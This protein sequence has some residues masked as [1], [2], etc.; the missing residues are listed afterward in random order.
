MLQH[1]HP[2]VRGRSAGRVPTLLRFLR[3]FG[4]ALA[5]DVLPMRLL[6]A[7]DVLD[8]PLRRPARHTASCRRS[9]GAWCAWWPSRSL[10]YFAMTHYPNAAC[11]EQ[12]P[13]SAQSSSSPPPR[14]RRARSIIRLTLL[15]CAA[16]FVC[17]AALVTWTWVRL[18]PLSLARADAVSVTV[19][20]RNDRLLRAYTAPDG[21]WRLPAELK[22]VDPRYIAMLIAFEDKRFRR[23][24]GVD[25][26]AVG[27]AGGSCCGIAAS[28]PAVR[29]SPCR[30]RGCC[31]ASTTA[32]S[33]ARCRQ[34]LLALGLDWR[35]SKD[36]ILRLGRL[37]PFGEQ[38]GRRARG[39]ARPSRRGPSGCSVGGG[40]LLR[41]RSTVSRRCAHQ[42]RFQRRKGRAR[43]ACWPTCWSAA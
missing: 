41:R 3:R 29:P 40:G 36:Q 31:S 8:L 19:L 42:G 22:D 43:W 14:R 25:P 33:W 26:L 35:L 24:H 27:R 11:E 1:Q 39:V 32:R 10:Q 37:A 2:M 18:Q 23:H 20:D 9:C 28:S 38:P 13:G 17:V 7:L 16:L 6:V 34:A 21:R 30:W 15:A 4:L 12:P 5:L